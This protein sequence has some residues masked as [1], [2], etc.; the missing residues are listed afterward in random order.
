G[1]VA[2]GPDPLPRQPLRALLRWQAGIGVRAEVDRGL[3]PFHHPRVA[4]VEVLHARRPILE[5]RRQA[6]EP[7]VRRLVD[8]RVTRDQL[9]VPNQRCP[10]AVTRA[11]PSGAP[12][13]VGAG[14]T[15]D[16]P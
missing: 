6:V 1:V 2:A 5:L 16:R 3:S 15:P 14:A 8:V 13:P 10:P 11:P 12:T 4:V 7:E 9:V